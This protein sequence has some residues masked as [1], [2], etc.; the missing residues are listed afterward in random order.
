M[1]NALLRVLH[2]LGLDDLS[3]FGDSTGELDLTTA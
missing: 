2:I 3:S 1:A